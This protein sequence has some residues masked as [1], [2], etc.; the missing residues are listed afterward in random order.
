MGWHSCGL[1]TC[2]VLNRYRV[3]FHFAGSR[4]ESSYAFIH[5]YVLTLS[6]LQSMV[7][8]FVGNCSP[9]FSSCSCLCKLTTSRILSLQTPALTKKNITRYPTPCRSFWRRASR[10]A[11]QKRP[12]QTRR[13][14]DV[15]LRPILFC[16]ALEPPRRPPFRTLPPPAPPR[17]QNRRPFALP[18]AARDRNIKSNPHTGIVCSSR[19]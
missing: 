11:Q 7:S 9:A 8:S 19:G 18:P 14:H 10:H 3:V 16:L 13:R 17:P 15:D 5:S 6:V 2:M 12:N 4:S 1:H